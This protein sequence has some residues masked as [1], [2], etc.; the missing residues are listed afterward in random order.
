MEWR[1]VSC[2]YSLKS[3]QTRGDLGH[4][5]HVINKNVFLELYWG[6]FLKIY[7]VM[8][9][10]AHAKKV[11]NEDNTTIQVFTTLNKSS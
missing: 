3:A 10:Y 11:V 8:K 5:N 7:K 9:L 2:F 6:V 1:K 4:K